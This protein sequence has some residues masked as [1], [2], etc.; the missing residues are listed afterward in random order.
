MGRAIGIGVCDLRSVSVGARRS[1][2]SWRMRIA[3]G[4]SSGGVQGAA[5]SM[6]AVYIGAPFG[7]ATA[8]SSISPH[9]VATDARKKALQQNGVTMNGVQPWTSVPSCCARREAAMEGTVKE[10]EVVE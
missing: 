6:I 4:R 5:C 3:G 1:C 9:W 2:S 7:G 10:E 8:P